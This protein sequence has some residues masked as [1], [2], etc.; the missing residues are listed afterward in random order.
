MDS[1]GDRDSKPLSNTFGHARETVAAD[2][3]A[4]QLDALKS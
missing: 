2:E 1:G 4:A 3:D